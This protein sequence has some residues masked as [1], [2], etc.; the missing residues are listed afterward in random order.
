MK[1]QTKNYE[2]ENM[3]INASLIDGADVIQSGAFAKIVY[4]GIE[5]LP[6]K[7][8]INGVVTKKTEGMVQ[9]LYSYEN[10]VNNRIEKQGGERNF[11][12]QG[13]PFGQWF[14]PN[15]LISHKGEMYLRFY[16]FKGGKL[17]TTYFVDGK[18]ATENETMLITAYKNQRNASSGTQASAG[19]TANQVKPCALNTKNLISLD[20][21][22]FHY[23]RNDA[24]LREL[25]TLAADAEACGK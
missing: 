5:K 11:V 8:G 13:L 22:S 7:L 23:K 21:G 10:A 6:K 17:E 4:D 19:L 2:F 1:K 14:V 12:A 3:V 24:G 20:C 9:M 15:F 16:T 18:P 25:E